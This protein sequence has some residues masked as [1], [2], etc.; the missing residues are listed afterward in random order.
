MTFQQL[1]Y[2]LEI[3]KTGSISKTAEKLFVTRSS[4]SFSIRCLE[5]ELGYPVFLRTPS[6]LIP[7]DLGA[8]V[9]AHANVI[10][11]T[12][13][14]L[15]ALNQQKHNHIRIAT[16]DHFPVTTAIARLLKENCMDSDVMF[17][18][19]DNYSEPL[20]RLATGELDVVLKCGYPP[21]RS[22]PEG[23]CETMLCHIPVVLLLGPG[24]RLYHKPTLTAEDFKNEVLLE[25]PSRSCS[26]ITALRRTIPFDP[27]KAIAIRQSNLRLHLLREGICF[28]LRRLPEKTYLEQNQLRCLRLEGVHQLLCCYTNP[29]KPMAPE[30]ARFLQLLEEELAAYQEA[31]IT[32]TITSSK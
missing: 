29:S 1:Q 3:E 11:N 18:F 27:K 13:K 31:V 20:N 6:G 24:H 4:V 5:E 15:T 28:C 17:T 12:Q 10:C 21:F 23:L 2:L 8:Q 32:E 30:A 26:R 25:T 14:K 7:T 16:V 19:R 9:L 22:A